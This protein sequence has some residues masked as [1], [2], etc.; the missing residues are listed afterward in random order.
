MRVATGHCPAIGAVAALPAPPPDPSVPDLRFLARDLPTAL[1]SF[2]D[3]VEHI[4]A[5]NPVDMA[6][7][8]A[9]AVKAAGGPLAP[10][11]EH[12]L[13]SLKAQALRQGRA[14]GAVIG[15]FLRFAPYRMLGEIRARGQLFQPPFGPVVVVGGDAVRNVFERDQ[16][17][18]VEPYGVEMMTVMSP[19]HNGGF[20]TFVLSTDDNSLYEPD[21]HLLSA[22]CTREDAAAITDLIHEDCRR[23]LG[24]AI[25]EA[26]RTGEPVI[27]VVQAVARYVPVTLVHRY[28]EAQ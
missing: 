18:T 28:L 11:E 21:K 1:R 8:Q 16:E 12:H 7:L 2:F 25:A 15:F 3:T 4:V 6:G 10:G 5:D 9:L 17:F 26:R 27:D 22:V 14:I 13:R 19:Q 20:S 24:A 23:R